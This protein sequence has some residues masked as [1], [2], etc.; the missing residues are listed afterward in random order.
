MIPFWHFGTM[1]KPTRQENLRAFRIVGAL[2]LFVLLAY[3]AI[4]LT[5][6]GHL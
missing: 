5:V 2:L 6:F 4:A 3:G 1:R